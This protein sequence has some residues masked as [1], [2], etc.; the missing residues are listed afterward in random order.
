[1]KY[2]N[3]HN[4]TELFKN[5]KTIKDLGDILEFI[6]SKWQQ[7]EKV[8]AFDTKEAFRLGE[9]RATYQWVL[10]LAAKMRKSNMPEV[11]QNS[12]PFNGCVRIYQWCR[13]NEKLK[14]EIELD[15][16]D[17]QIIKL[18]QEAEKQGQKLPGSRKIAK[19]LKEWNPKYKGG[20]SHPIICERLKRLRKEG[21]VGSADDTTEKAKRYGDIDDMA[22]KTKERF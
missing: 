20:R 16:L 21:L 13:E 8:F 18:H 2:Y 5:C 3:C 1:M 12:D 19:A 14:D 9:K 4:A 22:D 6:I 11:P 15:E 7:G 17:V 10:F